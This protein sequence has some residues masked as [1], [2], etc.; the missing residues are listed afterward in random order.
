MIGIEAMTML[1]VAVAKSTHTEQPQQFNMIVWI[2]NIIPPLN[3]H[4]QR[5]NQTNY[6]ITVN[7]IKNK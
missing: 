1:D 4:D 2:N 5:R 6:T 7:Q 3:W